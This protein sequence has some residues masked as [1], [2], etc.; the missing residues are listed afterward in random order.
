MKSIA[1]GRGTGRTIVKVRGE[2]SLGLCVAKY[3][4]SGL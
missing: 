1:A 4:G 2:D 3:G